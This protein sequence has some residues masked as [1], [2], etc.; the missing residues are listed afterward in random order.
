M[1]KSVIRFQPRV[2]CCRSESPLMLKF[3]VVSQISSHNTD[4]DYMPGYTHFFTKNDKLWIWYESRQK[5]DCFN[6]PNAFSDK[7]MW[8][9]LIIFRLVS[10]TFE[11]CVSVEVFTAL[12]NRRAVAC[13][14][15]LNRHQVFSVF[16]GR[17][18]LNGKLVSQTTD[19]GKWLKL[20]MYNV[21][22]LADIKG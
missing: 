1:W 12:C 21:M 3:P 17:L 13:I 22:P 10:W 4:T 9:M 19:T 11:I 8:N 16:Y 20:K 15:D 6:I 18:C 2:K 7:E 5:D 14:Y